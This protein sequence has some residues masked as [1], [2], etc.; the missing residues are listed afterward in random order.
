MSSASSSSMETTVRSHHRSSFQAGPISRL[1]WMKSVRKAIRFPHGAKAFGSTRKLLRRIQDLLEQ[2]AGLTQPDSAVITA[3]VASS[4]FS[5]CLS[6]LPSLLISGPDREHAV[7]V[8]RMLQCL[9]RHAVLLGELDRNALLLFASLDATLLINQPGLPTRMRKLLSNTN[10]NGVHLVANG[11][12]CTLTGSKA[13]FLGMEATQGMKDYTS[14]FRPHLATCLA[15]TSRNNRRLPTK[16]NLRC[17]CTVCKTL[18]MSA[19]FTN[20]RASTAGGTEIARSLTASVL[21]DVD[22]LAAITARLRR[23]G[24]DAMAQRGN[25]VHLAVI[26]VAWGPAHEQREIAVSRLTELTN[27]LLRCRGETLVYNAA[28]IGWKL[29]G[30]GFPRHRNGSGMVL[31]FSQQNQSLLHHCA[32]RWSLKVPSYVECALCSSRETIVAQ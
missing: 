22:V 27:T 3:W 10:F 31:K 8:F 1:A 14:H 6:S 23:W 11:K 32:V 2:R 9:C 19:G 12:V 13:L 18:I 26:E 29:K 24:D 20:N 16:S 15:W 30:L 21:G 17:S 4:W 25:D 28:E 5:N 7:T